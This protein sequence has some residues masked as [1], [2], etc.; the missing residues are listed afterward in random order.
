MQTADVTVLHVLSAGAAQSVTEQIAAQFTRETGCGV[1][2]AYGA[3]GA[4][5]ARIVGGEAVDV[6]I[7]SAELIENLLSSGYLLPG[8]RRDLGV[9]VTGVAVRAG[10]PLPDVSDRRT[11]GGN[12]LAASRI[13]CPDP[14][15]ATAGKVVMAALDLLGISEQ[16][17]SR[18]KFF[19]NGYSAMQWLAES[20][21][22]LEMGI[23]QK[24]EILANNGVTYVGPLPE[25]LQRKTVYAAGV[26]AKTQ[27]PDLAGNFIDRYIAPAAQGMLRAAGYEIQN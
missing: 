3:V 4:M 22:A 8:S 26:A 5:H 12:L 16:V 18:L 25:A 21:G 19:P 23:T 20:R 10:T 2:A 6:I 11:I 7:L 15:V 24:T 14:A 1:E 9:V 13:V 27:H 17:R